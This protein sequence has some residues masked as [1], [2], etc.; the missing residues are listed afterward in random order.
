[1]KVNV[2]H[3]YTKVL[4]TGIYHC[5]QWDLNYINKY[6]NLFKIHSI[7]ISRRAIIKSLDNR[8]ARSTYRVYIKQISIFVYVFNLCVEKSPF[9]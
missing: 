5:F 3:C 2:F 9:I 6:T 7:R 1:M 8:S 4:D